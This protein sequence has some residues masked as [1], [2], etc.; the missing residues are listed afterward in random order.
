M[1]GTQHGV[2]YRDTGSSWH[3]V[4]AL[5]TIAVSSLA[6]GQDSTVWIGTNQGLYSLTG[7]AVSAVTP[8]GGSSI[9]A[10]TCLAVKKGDTLCVGTV[11]GL[12]YYARHQ[13]TRADRVPQGS[14][15]S[16][17][18]V[19]SENTVWVG[20]NDGIIRIENEMTTIIR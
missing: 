3:E 5:R 2:Y 10:V 12:Y 4:T 15:V 19:E 7:A 20:T 13:W 18:A 8:P 17:L 16:A 1:A 9:E 14:C 6:V 11:N